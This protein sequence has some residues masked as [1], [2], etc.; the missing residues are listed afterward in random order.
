MMKPI[1]RKTERSDT[2]SLKKLWLSS[3]DEDESAVN[4]IFDSYFDL[5]N[6]YC[7]VFDNEIVSALYLINGTLNGEKAH[8]LCSASTVEHF[9]GN[10]IMSNLIEFALDDAKKNGD[11][12]SL[13]FPAN[14]G[15]YDFYA[16]L[17]YVP[18]CSVKS[19]EFSR[20]TLEDFAKGNQNFTCPERDSFIYNE[21]FFEFAKAYYE[22]YGSKV[23]DRNGC[24][25]VFDE[26]ENTADV[27]YSAYK[28]INELS[29]LLLESTESEKFVFTGKSDNTL[30]ENCES[31][32]C[33]M[34]KSLDKNYKIPDDIYIGITLS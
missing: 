27:F 18:K 19:R 21:R 6:G 30:F 16:R 24:Y 26:N 7:A 22:V 4:L 12:Y 20:K 17:G 10:G 25:A 23:I 5:F 3:F 1:F 8:Y 34:I 9:R 15:L 33:G 2:D 29:S 11:V 28:N 13:L 14:D 31:Q 32:R